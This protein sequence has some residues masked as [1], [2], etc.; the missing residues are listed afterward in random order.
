MNDKELLLE[1]MRRKDVRTL[2][3]FKFGRDLSPG[4][5]LIVRKIAFL[6][7]KRISIR[8]PTRYGKTQ[9]VAD[10]VSLILDFGIPYK[11]AF[12]GPMAEQA[13]ILRQYMADNI[14][15][16]HELLKKAQITSEGESRIGK[17]ASRKRM[18]FTT[19][20]EYRV[21]SAEGEAN[22]LMGFGA[23][24]IIKDESCLIPKIANSK[25][26]RMAGDNPENAIIIEL[27]NPWNRDNIAFEH[28]LDPDWDV[29]HINWQQAV[30]EGR[31]TQE[32]VDEQRKEL[33]PLEFTVLYDSEFPEQG[34][35][36]LFN[37]ND[38]NYA[39]INPDI[40]LWSDFIKLKELI[41]DGKLS[42]K[43][44]LEA[45]KK[46]CFFKKKISC[47]PADKG[48]DETVIYW[49][50][51]DGLYYEVIG[52]YSEPKSENMGIANRIT[53]KL[54]SDMIPDKTDVNVDAIG[55]GTGPVS[56]IKEVIR[57]EKWTGITVVSCKNGE[58]AMDAKRYPHK[59]DENYFRLN[60]L[61]KEHL[62]KIP[63]IPKLKSQLVSIKWKNNSV[64]K[65][66]VVYPDDS[67]DYADCLMYFT[68]KDKSS[69]VM[70]FV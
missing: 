36:S 39:E 14:L 40:H 56:R 63:K 21:F 15:A 5:E 42:D 7:S 11:I 33:T 64:G 37:L 52:Y 19:G 57:D 55:I 32:F 43:E 1:C 17:E 28:T 3:K 18:T 69:L 48:R 26:M 34:E 24:I 50:I 2:V 67:P 10:A 13:A 60:D 45:K 12:I 23:D 53:A 6:E 49:G 25:I 22:R 44:L 30:K 20:A 54:R 41:N 31:T 61:F 9:C 16:D 70:G 62:I 35:D 68:W 47:D 46:Y 8:A 58:A 66:E 29:I 51:T 27:M 38:I 65:R 4:Q 59:D